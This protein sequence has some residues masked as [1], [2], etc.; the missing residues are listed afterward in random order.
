MLDS[1]ISEYAER[2]IK[3][4]FNE[5]TKAINQ[6]ATQIANE[7]AA[8]GALSSGISLTLFHRLC[9]REFEIRA[10]IIWE[11][12]VRAHKT[13][14]SNLS[15]NLASDLKLEFKKFIDPE[16]TRLMEFLKEK[17]RYT[18]TAEQAIQ[19]LNLDNIYAH[20]IDKHYIEIELY[21]ETLSQHVKANVVLPNQ[22]NFYG[23][24]GAVQT[25]AYSSAN[26]V[27][28]IG[29]DNKEALSKALD[30]VQQ[31]IISVIEINQSQKEELSELIQDCRN[32]LVSAKPNNTK[33]RTLLVTLATSIQMIADAQ[34]AYQ[35]LKSALLVLGITLP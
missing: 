14:A 15:D 8:K 35:A 13:C 22:Y 17:F 33:L 26:A 32:Q 25:G 28:N 34:P 18:G 6:E 31:T 9:E 1:K 20:V 5:R 21:V 2:L 12:L 19:R 23:N 11:N 7:L 3:I 16:K 30:L 10:T 4:Y 29:I 27:Q 24:I